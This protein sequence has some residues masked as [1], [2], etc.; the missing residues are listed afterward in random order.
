[1]GYFFH[2]L[3]ELVVSPNAGVAVGAPD[4]TLLGVFILD[5]CV[6]VAGVFLEFLEA[7]GALDNHSL[8]LRRE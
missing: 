7:L 2:A 5:E 3:G 8:T 4:D 1:V 6:L